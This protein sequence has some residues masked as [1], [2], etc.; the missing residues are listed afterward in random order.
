[1]G[2]EFG[3]VAWLGDRWVW[4]IGEAE[5]STIRM[6]DGRYVNKHYD[7]KTRPMTSTW[8]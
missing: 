8:S 5:V 3:S 4:V 7:L 1:V 6:G 2:V